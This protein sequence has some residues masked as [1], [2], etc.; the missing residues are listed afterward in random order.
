MATGEVFAVFLESDPL[1]TALPLP[2]AANDRLAVVRTGSTYYA[3][4]LALAGGVP[5]L[6]IATPASGDTVTMDASARALYVNS[7]ALA[8]LTVLLPVALDDV[9]MLAE[10]GLAAPV[11]ALT[12]QS[13]AAV[14]VPTAPTSGFG[15]GAAIH[16][17]HID[18][19]T[20][21]VYWK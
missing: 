8:A 10:I 19:A 21:W 16:M 20:G 6:Q 18:L 2:V 14:T 13:A 17:R 3:S 4:A 5:V 9:T 1:T 12:I 11:T 15:P 7:A